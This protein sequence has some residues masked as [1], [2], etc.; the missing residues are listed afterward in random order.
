MKKLYTFALLGLFFHTALAQIV[1]IPDPI[2]KAR[3]ISEGV[4][5]SGDGEIQV[6]EAQ[7]IVELDV[8]NPVGGTNF[9]QDLSGI[10]AFINLEDLE[11]AN[12]QLTSLDVSAL[13]NL[14]VLHAEYNE[15]TSINL[16][17]L[18]QLEVLWIPNNNL[19]TLHLDS[20]QNLWWLFCNNNG[21]DT[22]DLS[23]L[24]SLYAI[25]AS[26]NLLTEIDFSGNPLIE[27][28]LIDTNEL[29]A[30]D[31][32]NLENLVELNATSNDIESI[33][34]D[35]ANSLQRLFLSHNLLTEIDCSEIPVGYLEITDNPNLETINVQNGAFEFPDPD[36][37]Y[38]PLLLANTPN[39]ISICMD[40]EDNAALEVSEYDASNVIVLAGPNCTPLSVAENDQIDF[41]VYPNPVQAEIHISNY[42]KANQFIL[43]D[44]SGKVLIDTKQYTPLQQEITAITKGVYF[45]SIT[46]FEQGIQTIKIIKN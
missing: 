37:L 35:G 42:E 21:L 17:G 16:D 32:S 6:S 33:Q 23:N 3:L 13:E 24:E 29:T 30:I 28:I 34:L 26:G 12:N 22:L 46:T 10:E 31:I 1:S 43:Y 27:E 20:L 40:P 5:T 14:K 38:F 11:C 7:S 19:T 45:L 18:Q 41:N 9:I 8:R 36:L 2:F 25:W 15:L 4:D 44:L 39:L